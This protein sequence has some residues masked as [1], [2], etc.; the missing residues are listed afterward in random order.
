MTPVRLEPAAIRSRV[1][2]ST[3]EPLRS[4]TA[5]LVVLMSITIELMLSSSQQYFRHV[6]TLPKESEGQRRFGW[7]IRP[8]LHPKSNVH[9]R[10]N[11]APSGAKTEIKSI[12]RITSVKV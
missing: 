8:Q 4:L 5:L 2:R 6:G 10:A 7:N 1:K 11:L 3:T 12:R 9:K